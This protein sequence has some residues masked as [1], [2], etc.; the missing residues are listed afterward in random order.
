M[1]RLGLVLSIVT[2]PLIGMEVINA[3]QQQPLNV[4]QSTEDA[5]LACRI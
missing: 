5:V 4:F 1:L 3:R 2:L